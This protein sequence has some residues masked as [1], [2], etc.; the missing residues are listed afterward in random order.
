MSR[1]IWPGKSVVTNEPW[2]LTEDGL[3]HRS[4]ADSCSVPRDTTQDL[5]LVDV[6]H[7]IAMLTIEKDRGRGR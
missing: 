3:R 4:C 6:R 7:T 1:D 2:L 5:G